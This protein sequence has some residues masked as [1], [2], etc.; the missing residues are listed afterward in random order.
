MP[1]LYPLVMGR[2]NVLA[3]EHYLS[4]SQGARIFSRGGN[5]IDAAVAAVFVEGIVNPHLH[6]I[7]GEAPMLIYCPSRRKV[8][9]LNGNMK[10]PRRATISHY[11]GLGLKLIP[12]EGLLA[13]GVPAAFDA[14][15]LA[16]RDFGTLSLADVLEPALALCEDGFPLHPGLVGGNDGFSGVAGAPAPVTISANAEKFTT[17]WPSSGRLYMPTGKVPSAGTVLRNP[18]LASNGRGSKVAF[19]TRKISRILLLRQRIQ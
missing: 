11:Q 3:T 12:H 10:A 15:A 16:L 13:A 4:A 17:K 1:T 14:L 7:G 2:K 8:V 9:C 19:S 5:A 6:T 18:A